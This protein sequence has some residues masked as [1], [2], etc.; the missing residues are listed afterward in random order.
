MTNKQ[1]LMWDWL[2]QRVIFAMVQ[3]DLTEQHC[4]DAVTEAEKELTKLSE[5]KN[6]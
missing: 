5:M 2:V 6:E 1:K 4:L 3:G